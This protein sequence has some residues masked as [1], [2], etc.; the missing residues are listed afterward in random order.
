[1]K[2]IAIDPN[3]DFFRYLIAEGDKEL[4]TG[5]LSTTAGIEDK[6]FFEDIQPENVF[7]DCGYK[8]AEILSLCRHNGYTPVKGT[9][10]K[11][12]HN[13]YEPI[14]GGHKLL[15]LHYQ[16]MTGRLF[17]DIYCDCRKMAFTSFT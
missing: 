8:T 16:G 2:K 5:V 12:D 3:K 9:S 10:K 13:K 4:E 1:M 15:R 6:V 7:I 11:E 17:E 14:D